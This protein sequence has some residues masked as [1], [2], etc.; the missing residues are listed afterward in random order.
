MLELMEDASPITDQMT[1][2]DIRKS[3]ERA[4]NHVLSM[5]YQTLSQSVSSK[6]D[7]NYSNNDLEKE[8]TRKTVRSFWIEQFKEE[9]LD[10]D[11]F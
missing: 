5:E 1:E 8:T 2:E 4:V 6:K 11:S 10:E 7:L 3:D 9:G